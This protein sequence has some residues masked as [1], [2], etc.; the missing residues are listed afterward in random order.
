MDH[1]DKDELIIALDFVKKKEKKSMRDTCVSNC[2]S[3]WIRK[4]RG[5]KAMNIP[6]VHASRASEFQ[7]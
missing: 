5:E 3:V 1:S 2:N 4:S 7:M 6:C